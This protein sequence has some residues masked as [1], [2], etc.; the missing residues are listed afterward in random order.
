LTTNDLPPNDGFEENLKEPALEAL[1]KTL[2]PPPEP[3][4][5]DLEDLLQ[6]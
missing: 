5:S 1:M 4:D 6:G 3:S 2:G